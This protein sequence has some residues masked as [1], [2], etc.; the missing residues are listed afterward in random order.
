LA[1]SWKYR[2]GCQSY[3]EN[4]IVWARLKPVEEWPEWAACCDGLRA[5]VLSLNL[6]LRVETAVLLS[7][8]VRCRHCLGIVSAKRSMR[9]VDSRG[10][11]TGQ[12]IFVELFD[13]DEGAAL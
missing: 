1:S 12:N 10:A 2:P 11:A 13:L 9:V 3:T 8:P 7:G 6:E 4:M 5:A